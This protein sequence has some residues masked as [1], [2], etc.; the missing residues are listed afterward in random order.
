MR[1]KRITTAALVAGALMA[2]TPQFVGA[3][4]PPGT[5][6]CGGQNA[7]PQPAPYDCVL[8]PKVIDGT[9]FAG[10]VHANGTTVTVTIQIGKVVAGKFVPGVGTRTVPT[11][12]AI[13]HHQDISGAGGPSENAS[14][15]I[16]P[17]GFQIVLTD[18]SPCR[19]GQLDVFV[20]NTGP[21]FRLGGPWIQNGTGCVA[22]TTVATT[23]PTTAPGSTTP[24]TSSPG[25]TPAPSTA[26]S[27]GGPGATVHAQV[28]GALP[29]TG[30]GPSL[31]VRLGVLFLIAGAAGVL[32]GLSRKARA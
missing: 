29:P 26:P 14:G 25:T 32:I 6:N 24:A 11:P 15:T 17:G 23:P 3:Q 10:L 4:V 2:L 20:V 30:N 22:P 7:A 18:S 12:A 31:F 9:T 16:P 27:T 5:P 21:N 1:L 8:P 19:N 13:I 28:V